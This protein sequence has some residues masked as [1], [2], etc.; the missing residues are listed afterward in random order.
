M[1]TR[2]LQYVALRGMGGIPQ[3]VAISNHFPIRSSQLI[4][5]RFVRLAKKKND[6][7]LLAKQKKRQKSGGL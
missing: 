4:Q 1:N 7:K 2:M 5:P 6:Q 3:G